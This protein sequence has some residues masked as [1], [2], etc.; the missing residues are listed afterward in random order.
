MSLGRGVAYRIESPD[1]VAIRGD[2]AVE[3]AQNLVY[4]DR[5]G[6]IGY[7][8]PGQVPV[9][10]AALPRAPAGYWP[11]PG[12]DSTYDWE[13]YVDLACNEIRLFGE[14]DMQI[15]RRMRHMLL[16]LRAVCPPCRREPIDRALEL[17]DASVERGFATAEDRAM[18][19]RPDAEGLVGG[20]PR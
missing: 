10:R 16:D 18:A 11:A 9:R 4:A 19:C 15:A 20:P 14:G 1:L 5:Q 7:Q 2:L 8:A 17:L 12:W 3:T 13:G 6:H